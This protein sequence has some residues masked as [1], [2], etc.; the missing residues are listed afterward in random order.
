MAGLC[1]LINWLGTEQDLGFEAPLHGPP[2]NTADDRF[3][4]SGA[5]TML[6][7][8]CAHCVMAFLSIASLR[9]PSSAGAWNGDRGGPD[10]SG[11]NASFLGKFLSLRCSVESLNILVSYGPGGEYPTIR[12]IWACT[13]PQSL[14]DCITVPPARAPAVNSDCLGAPYGG[15]SKFAGG[16]EDARRVSVGRATCD[17]AAWFR[18]GL[19]WPLAKALAEVLAEA[20][21]ENATGMRPPGALFISPS[22]WSAPRHRVWETVLHSVNIGLLEC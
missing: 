3:F 22:C 7:I 18:C 14:D 8:L 1:C 17:R 21:A 4:L 10:D 12:D 19:A 13:W 16:E 20:L 2:K 5:I 6:D 9:F 15:D 11:N